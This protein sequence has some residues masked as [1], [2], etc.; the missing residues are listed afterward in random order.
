M[1]RRLFCNLSS[2]FL[3]AGLLSAQPAPLSGFQDE[4]TFFLV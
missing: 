2:L 1:L 3:F 4:G